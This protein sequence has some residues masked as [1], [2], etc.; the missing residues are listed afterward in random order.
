MFDGSTTGLVLGDFMIGRPVTFNQGTV[1]GFYTRPYYDSLYAQDNWKVT[2]RLTL[3]YGVRWEPYLSPYNNRG[4][5]EH[6]DLSLFTQN[7]HSKVFTN[8]PA[9]L[10]FPGDPQYTSGKYINGPVWDKFFP[11]FG[12]AWD[13]EG[14]GRMTIRAGYGMYGDRA[15]M[16]AGTQMYF[17]APFGN[18]VSVAGANL[19]NPWTG[20][21]GNPLAALASLQGVGVYDHN[22][23]FP[24]NGTYVNTHMKDFHPVYMNQ[25]NLSIQRQIGQDWLV[26][27]NYLGNNTI[28]MITTENTNPAVFLGTGPCTL[29]TANGPVNYPVCSTT[30][31]QQNRRVLSLQNPAQGQY[32]AGIGQ[33][34]DGATASYE[35]LNLSVQKR[36]S[37]GITTSAN[38]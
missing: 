37:H 2:P 38:Y 16:L 1:Y 19:T 20:I 24:L 4:E 15:M 11:R 10:V 6:F 30:A 35:G 31:N 23:P 9:G 5:N 8:A 28:H 7:V 25:W 36:L 22:I 29:Q 32:Y 26:T 3:N 27:A 34:D 18:N 13:P 14:Q 21:G 17:S 33:I 12:L